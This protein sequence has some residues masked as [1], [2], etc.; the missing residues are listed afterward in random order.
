MTREEQNAELIAMVAERNALRREIVC[1][2]NKLERIAQAL[3]Q[4]NAAIGAKS[5]LHVIQG[6]GIA[7]G[8]D[9]V[10]LPPISDILETQ[11]RRIEAEE[12][13]AVLN[14]RIDGV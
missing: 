2:E 9:G 8:I 5:K 12:R 3:R 4:V 6:D 1:L 7:A 10:T 11:N 14:W 13:L